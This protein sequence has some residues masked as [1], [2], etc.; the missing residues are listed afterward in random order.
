MRHLPSKLKRSWG[1]DSAEPQAVNAVYYHTD[2]A[3]GKHLSFFSQCL[4]KKGSLYDFFVIFNGT[5][6]ML[7]T[8]SHTNFYRC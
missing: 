8:E 2:E 6:I 7:L 4:I 1:E 5:E 3:K